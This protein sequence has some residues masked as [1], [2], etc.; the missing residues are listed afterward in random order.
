MTRQVYGYLSAPDQ[1][2]FVYYVLTNGHFLGLTIR[3]RVHTKMKLTQNEFLSVN[4]YNPPFV[5]ATVLG[6]MAV[7]KKL[8]LGWK[9]YHE[10]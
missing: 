10:S 5:M 6:L 9:N 7:F 8:S 1:T 4:I 2:I 3:G